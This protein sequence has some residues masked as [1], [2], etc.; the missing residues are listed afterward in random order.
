MANRPIWFRQQQR[1]TGKQPV[2]PPF[3]QFG[4]PQRDSEEN[5][6]ATPRGSLVSPGVRELAKAMIESAWADLWER[7]SDRPSSWRWQQ[8]AGYRPDP[9]SARR[10]L[11]SDAEAPHGYLPFKLCCVALGLDESAVR[12]KLL[13]TRAR[14]SRAGVEAA[15]GREVTT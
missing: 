8:N 9:E 1:P 3:M 14:K 13:T 12:V 5:Q 4:G 11:L 2:I 7:T 6:R 10:W 15:D